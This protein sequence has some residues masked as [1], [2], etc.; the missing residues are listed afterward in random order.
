MTAIFTMSPPPTVAPDLELRSV[1]LD[2][3]VEYATSAELTEWLRNISQETKGTA[4]EKRARV[5][6][7]TK[8]LTMPASGFPDQTLYYLE[9]YS[10]SEHLEGLCEVLRLDPNGTRDMKWRR[11]MREVGF[12]EGWLSRPPSPLAEANFVTEIVRPFVEWHIAGK[13]SSYEKGFYPAFYDDMEEILGDDYVHDQL[14]VAS[15]STLKIDFHLGHPQRAGVG[16]EFKMPANNSDLQ[17]AL[18]QMDQYQTRYGENLL[19]V[20]FPDLIDKAQSTLFIDK[21]GER[22][23]RVIV[24]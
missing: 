1:L 7:N 12:R 8:Y 13:R 19:V 16:V 4:D 15:G 14:P 24:K 22:N 2:Y 9:I 20:L 6:A 17:R 11:I 10:T 3:Y 18:G 21:L 5:R 23:I